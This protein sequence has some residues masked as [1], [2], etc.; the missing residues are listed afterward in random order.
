[1]TKTKKTKKP[2]C[3]EKGFEAGFEEGYQVA[4][5]VYDPNFLPPFRGENL[6]MIFS[7]IKELRK[8][9]KYSQHFVSNS[10]GISRYSYIKLEQGKKPLYINEAIALAELYGIKITELCGIGINRVPNTSMTAKS[11]N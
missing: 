6:E 5:R 10:I 9:H 7:D 3:L 4:R 1:M 2:I 8:K 11:L